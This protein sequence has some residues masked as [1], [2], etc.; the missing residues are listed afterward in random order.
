VIKKGLGKVH[1]GLLLVLFLPNQVNCLL[2]GSV[3]VR[4]FRILEIKHL[5]GEMAEMKKRSVK[6]KG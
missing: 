5:K 2:R 6:I 3:K 4:C 1:Q